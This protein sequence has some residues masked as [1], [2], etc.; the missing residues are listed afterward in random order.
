[1]PLFDNPRHTNVIEDTRG[2]F[3][4]LTGEREPDIVLVGHP[5]TMFAQTAERM[6]KGE[7]PHPL[8]NGA[9]AWTRQLAAAATDFERRVAQERPPK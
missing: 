4:K 8:L 9:Q 6:R 3:R 2:T 7:R 5:Q 1:V